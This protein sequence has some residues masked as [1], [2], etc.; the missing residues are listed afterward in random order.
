LYPVAL[1]VFDSETNDNW[2]WFMQLLK[3]AIGSPNGLAICTDAGQAIMM[4]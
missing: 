4:V 3:D 2:I 1:G